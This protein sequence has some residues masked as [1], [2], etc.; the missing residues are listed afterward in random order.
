MVGFSVPG[1]RE[2]RVPVRLIDGARYASAMQLLGALGLEVEIRP[3]QGE[4]TTRVGRK[5][6]RIVAGRTAIDYGGHAYH[7]AA[8]ARAAGDD[9][10]LPEE[11][12]GPLRAAFLESE[13]PN[14]RLP[15]SPGALRTVVVDPGHGGANTG[16]KGPGGILEKDLTLQ[17]SRL[18]A[19]ILHEE[20]G[21]RVVLTRETDQALSLP[22]R[23]AIANREHADLFVSV[24]A[25]ASPSHDASGYETFI[26]SAKASDAES[27]RIADEE[28]ASGDE[29]DAAAAAGFLD[30]TLQDLVRA[31]SMEESAR[32]ASLVQR[33]MDGAM[34]TEDRGV[35]QAPFWVLAG[36]EMPAVLVEIGFVT[37]PREAA[38]MESPATQERIARAIA[39]AVSAFRVELDRRRGLAA[40]AA[41]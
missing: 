32:F 8:A 39:S 35:K 26:L 31:E 22:E 7:T 40:S 20:L 4:L 24:H 9:L 29:G 23:T 34:G 37:N 6:L 28:N 38:R 19:R 13:G 14:A 16:A 41:P 27:K 36:A 18:L 5:P 25:N 21:C 10:L 1:R 2:I 17:V 30:R 3:S 15:E 12:L 11:F 33:F